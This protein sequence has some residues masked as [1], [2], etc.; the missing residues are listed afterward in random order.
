VSVELREAL[1]RLESVVTALNLPVVRG[2]QPPLSEEEVRE[3]LVGQDFDPPSD[4]ITVFGW[5]DGYLQPSDESA[6]G[7]WVAPGMQFLR[8]DQ[9]LE[10]YGPIKEQIEEFDEDPELRW[11]PVAVDGGGGSFVINCGDDPETRGTVAL[12]DSELDFGEAGRLPGLTLPVTWWADFLEDGT[13]SYDPD[14]AEGRGTW[15][16]TLT[17][18][19]MTPEQLASNGMV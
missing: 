17:P 3:H 5:H 15:D 1:M 9:A 12:I 13:Y 2:L 18:D 8:L 4:V 7:G 6:W 11:F 16:S 19:R 14:G 10:A